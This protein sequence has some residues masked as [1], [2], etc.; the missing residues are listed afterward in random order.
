[1]S[2]SA[3]NIGSQ[4]EKNALSHLKWKRLVVAI[5]FT[6]FYVALDRTTVYFQM[7]SGISSW[8]P[9]SGVAVAI[10]LGMGI[11][12]A[13]VILFASFV[14][15]KVNYHQEIFSYSFIFATTSITG[16]YAAAA[17]ALRRLARID[18]HLRTVR[19]VSWLLFL[20]L[21]ASCGVAFL[22]TLM[23]VLDHSIAWPEY[24]KA[25]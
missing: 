20:A 24:V 6:V 15:A 13:P 5:L 4:F 14:A 18:W 10:L 9:P 22:G 11:G 1:M 7:W 21:P 2:E 23:L 17:V 19:D 12:Y 3:N 8:Y 25:A 16:G